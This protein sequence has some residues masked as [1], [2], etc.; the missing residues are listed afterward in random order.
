MAPPANTSGG[1]CSDHRPLWAQ[2]KFNYVRDQRIPIHRHT[3]K[4]STKFDERDEAFTKNYK[5]LLDNHSGLNVNIDSLNREQKDLILEQICLISVNIVESHNLKHK[6][7]KKKRRMVP[8]IF[9][10]MPTAIRLHR[11]KETNAGHRQETQVDSRQH[12]RS[13]LAANS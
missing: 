8:P 2:F 10:S 4:P 9:N 11:S 7:S 12:A 3:P 13:L 5:D 6:R 1:F